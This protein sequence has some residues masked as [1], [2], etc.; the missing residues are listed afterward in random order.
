MSERASTPIPGTPVLADARM[1]LL[2]PAA[3]GRAVVLSNRR[4]TASAKSSG[5]VR[6]I[7]LDVSGT[8]LE[9]AFIAGQSFGIIP[10]GVDESGR[11]HKLRLYSIASPTGGEDGQGKILSTTVKR[12]IDEH[13]E[14]GKLFLGVAS[15]FLCDLRPGDTVSVTGPNGK[16]FVLPA[17]PSAHDY[18][19]IATGTGIAPFR[20]MIREIATRAPASRV[21]LIMGSP[22]AGDL[23]YHDELQ[24]QAH[25]NANFTYV[26]AL[27]RQPQAD[28]HPA[29]YVDQRLATGGDVVRRILESPRGLV[30]VCGVAGMELGVFK[31]MTGILTPDVLAQ[32]LTVDPDAL[33]TISTWERRMIHKS[34]RP[35]RRVFMEVY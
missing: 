32:Y 23:I 34:I 25:T 20:G 11:P 12:T 3:P 18:L 10:P 22:Y 13:W 14:S 4:C 33:A 24:A 2:T 7:E 6:H 35:T 1:H 26:T 29:M 21:V 19:F 15:N 8:P 31:T 30:Y 27:S 28:G 9:N 16:R 17:D 5:F